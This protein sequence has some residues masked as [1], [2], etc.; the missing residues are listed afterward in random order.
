MHL[1]TNEQVLTQW[2][3]NK[4]LFYAGNRIRWFSC[5]GI[6]KIVQV[7]KGS[8]EKNPI[9]ECYNTLFRNYGRKGYVQEQTSLTTGASVANLHT[10]RIVGHYIYLAGKDH[11][12]TPIW[13]AQYKSIFHLRAQFEKYAQSKL[14]QVRLEQGRS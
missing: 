3:A 11:E 14:E 7:M 2:A 5:D 13:L 1:K 6:R 10:L 8:I 4:I 9:I 12:L